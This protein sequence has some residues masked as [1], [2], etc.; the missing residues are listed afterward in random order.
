MR[1]T[2]SQANR[3]K[4]TPDKSGGEK[5]INFKELLNRQ[6]HEG[7]ENQ[8]QGAFILLDWERFDEKKLRLCFSCWKKVYAKKREQAER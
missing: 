7:E 8:F 4:R 6:V 5:R 3:N 1:E 2:Y